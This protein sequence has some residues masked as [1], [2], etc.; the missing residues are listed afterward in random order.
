MPLKTATIRI[1]AEGRDRG[2]AFLIT[3]MPASRLEL[4]AM[5]A[6]MALAK[7]GVE[8]PEDVQ[9]AGVEALA[10]FGLKALSAVPYEDAVALMGEMFEC[11]RWQSPD[12][13]EITRPLIETDIEELGTRVRLRAEVFTLHT[14]FS[15]A[16]VASK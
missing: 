6:F 14:G 12:N 9:S 5:R 7:G 10:R 1:T 2:K 3:E 11:V 13:P 16:G 4:W 15:F 8:V